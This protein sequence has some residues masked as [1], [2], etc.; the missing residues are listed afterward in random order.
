LG[1]IEL[2]QLDDLDANVDRAAGINVMDADGVLFLASLPA[3][4]RAVGAGEVL[5][6]RE[7]EQVLPIRATGP[8]FQLRQL[9]L[10]LRRTVSPD[11]RCQ[12]IFS[13]PGRPG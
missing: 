12:L 3:F 2:G 7:V 11:E 1:W 5:P 10:Q 9:V 6:S 8:G 4:A 13:P